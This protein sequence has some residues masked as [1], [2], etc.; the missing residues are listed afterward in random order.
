[1]TSGRSQAVATRTGTR[2]AVARLAVLWRFARPHTIVGTTVSVLGLYVIAADSGHASGALD[3]AATLLAAWTVNVAIVGLNQIEDVDLDRVNKPELPLAAAELTLAEAWRTVI[4]CAAIAVALA[5][6]QGWLESAAVLIALSVGAAYSSPPLRLKRFP[7]IA[8]LSIVLVRSA[9]VN[10]GVY[11]HFAGSVSQVPGVV[12]ALT[13]F[14]VPFSAAIALLKDV[15]DIEGDRLFRV[16]TFSVRLG[17]RRV[18]F[19]SLVLLVAAYVAMGVGGATLPGVNAGI[20]LGGHAAALMTLAWWA[21]D[22]RP[23]QRS[24][25]IRFYL[26]VWQLFFLEYAVVPASIVL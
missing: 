17:P 23:D 21:R 7:A 6:T 20:W 25:F 16:R 1:M 15:P 19:V 11:G 8:A 14:V 5:I 4:A 22:A 10:L 18:L 26:R 2:G 12:W 3:L 9:V 13:L 24:R